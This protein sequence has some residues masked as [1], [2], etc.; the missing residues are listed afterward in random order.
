[1]GYLFLGLVAGGISLAL[2]PQAFAQGKWRLITLAV[3][4]VAAGLAMT[5]LGAW[6]AKRGQNLVR[7]DRFLYGYLFAFAFAL[8]RFQFAT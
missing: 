6:R 5:A 2:A 1:M 7:L 8:V 3:A 4:P